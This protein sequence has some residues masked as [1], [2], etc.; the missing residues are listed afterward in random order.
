MPASWVSLFL[1]S[2]EAEATAARLRD[3]LTAHGYSLYDPFGLMPGRAYPV[4]ARLFVNP[5][6]AG[7]VQVMAETDLPDLPQWLPAPLALY[8]A[9]SG[10]QGRLQVYTD[11]TPAEAT[12]AL[13]P[14]L[15]TGCTPHQ[16]AAALQGLALADTEDQPQADAFF[17][18][19]PDDV[20]GLAGDVNPRQARKLFDR[21]SGGF[22][23][24]LGHGDQDAAD[25]G[26]LLAAPDWNSDDGRRIRAVIACLTIPEGWRTPDYVTLRD[27]YQLHAR[28]KRKP[29][30][31]LYPG[32]A[33][34]LAQ[35]P[36]A[37]DYIPVFG[38][39]DES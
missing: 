17:A 11:G 32:D 36:D 27:A 9:L 28:R 21:I 19:L 8:A 33:E 6:R 2:A 12:T 37:L 18:A 20:K 10:D 4:T 3:A 26:A 5:A 15:R 30:A 13:Q 1:H 34:V 22:A 7:W 31:T 25:A 38:G 35:V 14:H 24:R 23:S 29:D 16:L 39:R